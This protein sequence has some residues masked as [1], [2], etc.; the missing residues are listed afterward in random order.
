MPTFIRP[1]NDVYSF[2][3]TISSG[4]ESDED[5]VTIVTSGAVE[6]GGTLSED[7]QL[8]NIQ[9]DA[10]MPDYIVSEDL[11]VP[12]GITL[13]IVENDVIVFF[14]QETGIHV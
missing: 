3:L 8:K 4:G 9:P 10:S 14:E 12:N 11:I 6:I 7:L 5:Q 2:T 1:E 13:S